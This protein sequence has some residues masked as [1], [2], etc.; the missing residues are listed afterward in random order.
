M[1]QT[2]IYFQAKAA[3]IRDE[4]LRFDYKTDLSEERDTRDAAKGKSPA[5]KGTARVVSGS[6]SSRNM[7]SPATAS[8]SSK[9][10]GSPANNRKD[11]DK[12]GARRKS[13]GTAR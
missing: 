10:A 2:R 5:A 7:G 3:G 1:L 9:T 4:D 8:S 13:N 6:S 12:G 11:K